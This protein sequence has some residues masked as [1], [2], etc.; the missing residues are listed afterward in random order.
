MNSAD[1]G[2][3]WP[4]RSGTGSVILPL[5][6]SPSL[7]RLGIFGLPEADF[8]P[9]RELHITLLSTGEAAAVAAV[10]PESRWEESFRSLSWS[11]QFSGR[12]FLLGEAK[13]SGQVWTV[14]AELRDV[15]INEF[16]QAVSNA[17]GVPLPDTLP[18]VTLWVAGSER[19]I[20]L[21]SL[22]EFRQRM[23]RP[24]SL[25]NRLTE[26]SLDLRA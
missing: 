3:G 12:A 6:A 19:G 24:I 4:G 18:H 1:G 22:E 7:A 26:I 16:R 5:P 25:G 9:K 17:A 23:I 2:L 20:G 21:G 8:I 11:I 13:P 14:I 15:P 10:V